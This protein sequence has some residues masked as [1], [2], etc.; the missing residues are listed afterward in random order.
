L[1]GWRLANFE[2]PET[3]REY[4]STFLVYK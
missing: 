2:T 3:Q 4:P 1:Q